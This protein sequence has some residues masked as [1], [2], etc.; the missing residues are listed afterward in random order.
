M[1]AQKTQFGSAN[2]MP[3]ET[4]KRSAEKR[5]YIRINFQCN[6]LIRLDD[7]LTFRAKVQNISNAAVQVTCDARYALMVH[8]EGVESTADNGRIVDISIAL[9]RSNNEPVEDF[10]ARCRVKYCVKPNIADSDQRMVL[11]LQFVSM[12]FASIERLD[13]FIDEN[14]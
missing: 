9:P 1:T 6:A 8:P 14:R 5:K 4:V 3:V 10:K 2:A 12:D 7:A 13:A 11:G